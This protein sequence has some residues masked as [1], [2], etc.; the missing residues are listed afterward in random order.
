MLALSIL[1]L[2][3]RTIPE[4]ILLIFSGYILANEK[5]HRNRVL[6]SGVL[7]GLVTYFVRQ[8]PINFG[9]HTMIT[10]FAYIL[11]MYKLNHL[12]MIKSIKA[13]IVSTIIIS[14]FDL[15]LVLCYIKV[16]HIDGEILVS[17]SI[18]SILLG[19]PS[20]LLTYAVIGTVGYIR[21]HRASVGAI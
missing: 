12:D 5:I 7:L 20:L 21:K 18:L 16:F 19:T 8:L 10:L 9:I 13:A 6:I 3:L 17:Q 14:F 1:S 11:L 4:G 2:F 15:I